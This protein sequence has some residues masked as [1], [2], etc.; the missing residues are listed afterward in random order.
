MA[1]VNEPGPVRLSAGNSSANLQ[2]ID[3]EIV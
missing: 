2:S 3:V 1:E